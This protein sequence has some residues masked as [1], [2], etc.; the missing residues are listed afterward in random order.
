M[1]EF[2]SA[3]GRSVGRRTPRGYGAGRGMRLS[4]VYHKTSYGG[5][6]RAR[7]WR[8]GAGGAGGTLPTQVP[9]ARGPNVVMVGDWRAAERF[10]QRSGR[11]LDAALERGQIKA[12]KLL[13]KRIQLGI[14][15][16]HPAGGRAF[17]ALHPL[18]IA[19]KGHD[20]PLLDTE[21]MRNSVTWKKVGILVW[22]VGV[23]RG[24]KHKGSGKDMTELAGIHEFGTT[25][26]VT[27]PMFTYLRGLGL[28][29]N[30]DTEY[31]RIPARPFL[32]PPMADRE[33]QEDMVREIS[34]EVAQ[35]VIAA[36]AGEKMMG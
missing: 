35:A 6:G 18:T 34:T 23:L 24:Q 20:K 25:L 10:L 13:V 7:I 12:C 26:R 1:A 2:E 17:A 8:S 9:M 31:I 29:L 5:S 36:V 15:R 27:K 14:D 3:Y 32:G 19:L 22:F 4:E 21:E 33:T 28:T 30:V 11:I 16:G